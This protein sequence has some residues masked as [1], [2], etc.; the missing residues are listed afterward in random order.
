MAVATLPLST[1]LDEIQASFAL[2]KTELARL[3]GVSRQAVDQWRV[4]GVPGDRQEKAA[5][6]AATA[7]LLSHQLKSERLPGIAR[8]P[9]RAY[10]GMTMLEMIE[11]DRHGELLERVRAAFDWSSGS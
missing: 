8:R 9:A 2:S 1:L 7:D 3:F 4:R 11:R 6:V 10:G 5:T